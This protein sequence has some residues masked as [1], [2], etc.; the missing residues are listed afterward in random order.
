MFEQLF[1]PKLFLT[2]LPSPLYVLH[3]LKEKVHGFYL[4]IYLFIYLFTLHVENSGEVL[5][6][7]F[8]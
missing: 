7:I 5:G 8:K 1:L 3:S 2:A 6:I 4:F